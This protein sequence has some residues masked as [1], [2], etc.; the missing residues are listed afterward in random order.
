MTNFNWGFIVGCC[1]IIL[2]TALVGQSSAFDTPETQN[3]SPYFSPGNPYGQGV[4][5]ER[6]THL[7]DPCGTV[8]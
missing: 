7:H 6:R 2:L 4:E 8:E 5:P 3:S 1:Y